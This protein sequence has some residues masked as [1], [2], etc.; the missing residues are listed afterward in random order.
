MDRKQITIFAACI[1]FIAHHAHASEGYICK[2]RVDQPIKIQSGNATFTI[3]AGDYEGKASKDDKN[4]R[5]SAVSGVAVKCADRVEVEIANTSKLGQVRV[6]KVR[7]IAVCDE[8]AQKRAV[9]N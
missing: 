3:P 4:Y 8:V 1:F 2:M 5:R 9:C 6:P 7:K